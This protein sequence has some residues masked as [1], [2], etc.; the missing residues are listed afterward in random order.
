MD[1]VLHLCIKKFRFIFLT[2]HKT[3][4]SVIQHICMSEA[5]LSTETPL[6][7]AAVSST[8]HLNEL[9]QF[10]TNLKMV[11]FMKKD[12]LC[13]P[14]ISNILDIYDL[15]SGT[16]RASRQRSYQICKPFRLHTIIWADWHWVRN[17]PA[18]IS[19]GELHPKSDY[20]VL[21]SANIRFYFSS[22]RQQST[23][24]KSTLCCLLLIITLII[25]HWITE[26]SSGVINT[27][28]SNSLKLF[29]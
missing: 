15:R 11:T 13:I 8:A 27:L 17:V 12:L 28:I 18:I 4:L 26:D 14:L 3:F 21:H 20:P 1:E 7:D 25:H 22:N 19:R 9:E 29:H 16:L 2:Q 10:Q 23:E 24:V 5:T 6:Y